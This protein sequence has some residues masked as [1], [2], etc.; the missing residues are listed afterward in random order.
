MYTLMYFFLDTLYI[1]KA[2]CV[3]VCVYVCSLITRKREER[4]SP[5]FQGS[6]RVGCLEIF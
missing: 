5:N 6:C 2:A 3:Y 4:L 1:Y